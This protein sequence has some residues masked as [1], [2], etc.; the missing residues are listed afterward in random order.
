MP[1]VHIVVCV[2]NFDGDFEATVAR[3]KLSKTDALLTT[4][5]QVLEH[6]SSHAQKNALIEP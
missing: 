3:L 1:A 2:W 4:V 5:P 6:I